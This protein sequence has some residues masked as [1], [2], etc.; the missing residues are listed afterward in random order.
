MS[1]LAIPAAS[2]AGL[3]LLIAVAAV[4][5]PQQ[6]TGSGAGPAVVPTPLATCPMDK[7]EMGA[8]PAVIP[9]PLATC[10]MDKA[11]MGPAEIPT[12]VVTST[13]PVAW[14][15][16]DLVTLTVREAW[17]LSGHDYIRFGQMVSQLTNLSAQKRGFAIPDTDLA[18]SEI[19]KMIR[20][21]AEKDSNL[22]LYVAVDGSVLDYALKHD[23]K[24]LS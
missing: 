21:R 6:T 10:P 9:A 16:A 24:P 17:D 23:L 4:A 20:D 3:I 22:L 13:A 8:G 14:A 12:P 7:T 11:G 15:N 1:R 18:G 2:T 19:G 5:C